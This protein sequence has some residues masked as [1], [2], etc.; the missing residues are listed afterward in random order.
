MGKQNTILL[1]ILHTKCIKCMQNGDTMSI[2][3]SLWNYS[4]DFD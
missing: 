3:I 4:T 2:Y 1:Y